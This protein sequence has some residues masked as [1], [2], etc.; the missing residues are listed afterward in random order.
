MGCSVTA[1]LLVSDVFRIGGIYRKDKEQ[2]LMTPFCEESPA[3][4][5]HD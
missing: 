5:M 3:M 4:Q 2:S 1:P